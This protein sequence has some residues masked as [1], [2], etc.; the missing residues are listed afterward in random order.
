M[1]GVGG[2]TFIIIV[3]V[4]VVLIVVFF[5]IAIFLFDNATWASLFFK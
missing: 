5:V 2:V 3:I 4:V 1:E